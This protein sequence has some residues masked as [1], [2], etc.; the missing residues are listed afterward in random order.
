MPD[1]QRVPKRGR[2]RAHLAIMRLDH[3][4]KNIFVLPGIVVPM[5]MARVPL[6]AHLGLTILIGLVSCT[7]V[8]CSNYVLNEVLDAPFDR[9]HPTKKNRPVALRLVNI[10]LA[11]AQW[12]LMMVAGVG[13]GWTISRQFAVDGAGAVVDGLRVQHPAAADQGCAVPGC[14]DRE[15]EQSAAHVAGVVRGGGVAGAAAESC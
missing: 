8:A 6:T 15:R 5:E 2:L 12:M 7:L 14:A 11:Y 4:I 10:P 13:I 1:Q 3:S 9:L